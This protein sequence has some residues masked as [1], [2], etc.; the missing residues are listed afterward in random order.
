MKYF[1]IDLFTLGYIVIIDEQ[2][3]NQIIQFK[4]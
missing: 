1:M 2:V 3:E 4:V